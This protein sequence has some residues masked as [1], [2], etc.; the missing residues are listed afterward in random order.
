PKFSQD[1]FNFEWDMCAADV[2]DGPLSLALQIRDK[3]GNTAVGLPG[4]THIT[5]DFVCPSPL[6]ACVPSPDQIALF[7]RPNYSGACKVLDT[8]QYPN[9]SDLGLLGDN[10][11]ASILVGQHVLATLYTGDGYS[12]RSETFIEDDSNL[13]N[14]LIGSQSTSSLRVRTKSYP[15]NIPWAPVSPPPGAIHFQGES[16]SL[17][18]K[19]PTGGVEFRVELNMPSG[20]ISSNWMPEPVWDLTFLNLPTGSYNAKVQARNS[21]SEGGWSDATDFTIVANPFEPTPPVEAPVFHDM[22]DGAPGWTSSGLWHLGE[23]PQ[24]AFSGSHRWYY[25]HV[26]ENPPGNYLTESPNYGSLTSPLIYLPDQDTPYSLR[27]WYLYQ[28]ESPGKIWDRRWVQISK[29]GSTFENVLQLYNDLPNTW[30]NGILDLSEY[31]GSTIQV[32]FYFETLDDLFNEHEGWYID[33]FEISIHPFPHCGQNDQ[34]LIPINYGEETTGVICYPGNVDTFSFDGI[35]GD[36]VMIA[37]TTP[38]DSPHPDYDYVITLIDVDGE[39]PLAEYDQELRSEG[40]R[41]HIGF[42]ITRSGTYYLQV[43]HRLHPT[44]GGD[45]YSYALHLI[46]DNQRPEADFIFPEKEINLPPE[47]VDLLVLASERFPDSAI[48]MLS[49]LSRVEFL[50]HSGD[51][52]NDDWVLL[53]SDWEGQDI[54]SIVFDAQNLDNQK[55][56]AFFANVYDWAGNWTGQ[57]VWNVDRFHPYLYLPLVKKGIV[58]GEP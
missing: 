21:Y 55:G 3:S 47:E 30:L 45:E 49:G 20:S 41:P 19:V 28:T 9:S 42:L 22:E 2:P 18:W 10:K 8:G 4:L 29:D 50:W 11:A 36:R 13:A 17:A 38:E 53:G 37:L 48:H 56:M 14:T 34:E 40:I 39:S 27:F 44:I 6:P 1:F 23:D 58:L 35:A 33:D 32:R 7:T 15:P 5:K 26:P 24:R 51:W 43:R 25:G 16:L 31:A 54:W 52:L 46:K 57:P 12:G